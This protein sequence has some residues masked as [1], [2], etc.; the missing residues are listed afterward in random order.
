MAQQ[1]FLKQRTADESPAQS[2][3]PTQRTARYEQQRLNAKRPSAACSSLAAETVK[4]VVGVMA[5]KRVRDYSVV[6]TLGEGGMGEVL[7]AKHEGLERHVALKRFVYRPSDGDEEEAKERFRRE[8]RAMARLSHQNVAGVYDLF[9]WR[10]NAYM[11]LE[12]VDGFDVS[13]IIEAA[14]PCPAAVVALIALGVSRGL[15]A[16][17]DVG[18][19]HR[20][21]KASNVMASRKGEIKLMDFGIAQQQ[22]LEPMTRTGLV[23][24][25]PRYL[26]PEIVNGETADARSDIYGVGALMYYALTARRLFS[27]AKQENLF[28][29]ITA[30]KY[31]PVDQIVAGVPRDVR[32]VVQRCLQAEP[33]RRFASA[34]ELA[35]ALEQCFSRTPSED[36]AKAQL[37]ELVEACNPEAGESEPKPGAVTPPASRGNRRSRRLMLMASIIVFAIAAAAWFGVTESF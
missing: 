17:H 27:E 18:I 21:V 9:E 20:D 15:A 16:A 19:V 24:G 35:Q 25:T 8:G 36:D 28:Y 1:P 11:V 10:K 31:E 4:A 23:V 29:L 6:R 34:N 5:I 12:Y 32:R 2:G 3:L 30:G 22:L 33:E 13:A 7:L 26:A 37:A 14:G